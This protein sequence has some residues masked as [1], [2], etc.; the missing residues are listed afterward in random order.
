MNSIITYVSPPI[1]QNTHLSF[2]QPTADF[3]SP[4]SV[5]FIQFRFPPPPPNVKPILYTFPRSSDLFPLNLI[6]DTIGSNR[7][8]SAVTL[9]RNFGTLHLNASCK[10]MTSLRMFSKHNSI[11]AHL[12]IVADVVPTGST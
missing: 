2:Y 9:H 6:E 11:D 4:S 8:S 1:P 5:P 12:K 10:Q 7:F 3:F